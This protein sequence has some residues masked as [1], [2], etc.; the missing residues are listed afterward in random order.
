MKKWLS[1]I[2]M[3]LLSFAAFGQVTIFTESMGTVTSTTTI[4]AHESANGFD[5]DSFTMTGTAD[6]RIT[7]PSSGYTGVSGSANVFFGTGGGNAKEFI[8]SGI[9]T[10]NYTS[11][12]LS[13]GVL[14]SPASKALTVEVS[15]DGV[16]YTASYL[17]CTK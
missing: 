16:S 8:M 7:V 12:Q 17:F 15:S 5:N 14:S 1:I 3:F 13:F 11:L 4:A 9:N 2:S 6:V 10:S